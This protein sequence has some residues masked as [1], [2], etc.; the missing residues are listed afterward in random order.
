MANVTVGRA[1]SGGEYDVLH[2]GPL[3]V[4]VALGVGVGVTVAVALGLGVGDGVEDAL[5]LGDGEAVGS[6]DVHPAAAA[7]T[8]A[9][10]QKSARRCC[11]PYSFP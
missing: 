4:A 6:L 10:R 5:A 11:T 9:R 2:G 8:G 7:S 3:V 1:G